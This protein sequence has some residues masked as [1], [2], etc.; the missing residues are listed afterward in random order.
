MFIKTF[1]SG[2]TALPVFFRAPSIGISTRKLCF[3]RPLYY[4][5]F[6]CHIEHLIAPTLILSDKD[7][8][9]STEKLLI[10]VAEYKYLGKLKFGRREKF[11]NKSYT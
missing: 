1:C 6:I 11:S 7:I 8:V 2:R 10:V 5:V 4:A 3:Q 9:P